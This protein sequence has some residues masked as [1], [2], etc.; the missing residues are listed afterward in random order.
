[1]ALA[2]TLWSYSELSEKKIQEAYGM[3]QRRYDAKLKSVS[4]VDLSG[5]SNLARDKRVFNG[6]L[7]VGSS[8]PYIIHT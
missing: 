7:K 4:V 6:C 3:L 1:M 5:K 2:Q 8:L